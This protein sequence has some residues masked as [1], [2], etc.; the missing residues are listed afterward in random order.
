MLRSLVGSVTLQSVCE[1]LPR[2][3]RYRF[4]WILTMNQKGT[5]SR[6]LYFSV[7]ELCLA[8]NLPQLA[9]FHR[10]PVEIIEE[11]V[12][13]AVAQYREWRRGRGREWGA[14]C[15]ELA[16]DFGVWSWSWVCGR[17]WGRR[18]WDEIEYDSSCDSEPEPV[19]QRKHN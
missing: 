10:I 1:P 6:S 11:N 14:A 18:T 2:C 8:R 7:V 19:K 9:M 13:D 12:V 15:T 5:N 16:F 3:R 4:P 17:S